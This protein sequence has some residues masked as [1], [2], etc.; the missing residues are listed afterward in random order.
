MKSKKTPL[1]QSSKATA[2]KEQGSQSARENRAAVTDGAATA[3]RLESQPLVD[4]NESA[5]VDI[6]ESAEAFIR[7]F[8]QEL[9]LQR[10]QS[11]EN[12]KQMLARGT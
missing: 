12:Y 8:K 6:N 11:I 4:I 10:L 7:K 2:V 1:Y 5:E 3:K 9:R